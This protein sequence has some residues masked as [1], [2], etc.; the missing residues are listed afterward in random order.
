VKTAKEDYLEAV[1]AGAIVELA[2]RMPAKVFDLGS[3]RLLVNITI[4]S[5]A[6]A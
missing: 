4:F 6:A 2:C 5:L 1:A 3:V